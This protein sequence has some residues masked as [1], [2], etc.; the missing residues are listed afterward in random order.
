MAV[1]HVAQQE[2][3]LIRRPFLSTGLHLPDS[4]AAL[5]LYKAL[6]TQ[7]QSQNVAHIVLSIRFARPVIHRVGAAEN[8]LLV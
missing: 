2:C 8:A 5:V 1:P 4:V 6:R 7:I 3:G